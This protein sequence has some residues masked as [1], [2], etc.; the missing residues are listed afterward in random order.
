MD[1]EPPVASAF[2]GIDVPAVVVVAELTESFTAE[3]LS[4]LRRQVRAQAQAAGLSGIALDGFVVAVH[5]L[6]TNAVRH[7]GGH[8]RLWL[9][10]DGDNLLCDVTDEGAGFID[11][12]P[13]SAGPP[14]TDVV[15]GR[16][17]MLVRALTDTLLFSDGPDGVTA[18][19]TV[20]LPAAR[21][22]PVFVAGEISAGTEPGSD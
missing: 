1:T 11:G 22:A 8:G 3:R 16:G 12:V 10:S 9:R 18:T 21:Q 5:E 2:G 13:V 7:G 14:P 20:C 4:G 19:V 6:A 15:G 17:I